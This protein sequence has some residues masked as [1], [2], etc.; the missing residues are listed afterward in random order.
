MKSVKATNWVETA[1]AFANLQLNIVKCIKILT[2]A[3]YCTV[4]NTH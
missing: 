3:L 4:L 1:D 2:E